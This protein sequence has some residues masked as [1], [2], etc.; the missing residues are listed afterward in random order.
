[1]LDT[2][3]HPEE[4]ER[5]RAQIQATAGSARVLEGG[6]RRIVNSPPPS[7]KAQRKRH[8]GPLIIAIGA[9]IAAIAG[10]LVTGLF[11]QTG[12][13]GGQ[14]TLTAPGRT[15]VTSPTA[16]PPNSTSPS[17]TKTAVYWSGPVAFSSYGLDFDSSPPATDQTT[18][19]YLGNTLQVSANAQLAPWNQSG[20]PSASECRTW[21]TTHP[22]TA[23]DF[24]AVGMQ[25]CIRTDQGRY[26]LLRIDSYSNNSLQLNAN[27]T[28]WGL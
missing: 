14:P 20:V 2:P 18:I 21:V 6:G 4:A 12:S 13:P 25:I 22:N 7:R 9:I 17:T 16:E 1:M 3:A 15:P 24:P 28:I 5:D 10:A 23:V 26:G 8:T 27:A 19:Y 11:S